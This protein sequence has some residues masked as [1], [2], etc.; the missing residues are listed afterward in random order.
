MGGK[1]YG[2]DPALV[3]VWALLCSPPA[4]ATAYLLSKAATNTNL[5][6]FLV[7]LAFPLVPIIF[8]SR[9]RVTFEPTE[10]VYRRWGQLSESLTPT[11]KESR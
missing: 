11:S 3:G 9:F 5:V 4:F 1:S 6:H 2:A 8:A 7:S 10:F